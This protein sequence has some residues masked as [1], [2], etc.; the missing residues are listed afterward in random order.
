MFIDDWK[1]L[2]MVEKDFVKSKLIIFKVLWTLVTRLKIYI[3]Q[4]NDVSRLLVDN[5]LVTQNLLY[6]MWLSYFLLVIEFTVVCQE[7]L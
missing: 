4:S 2:M 7:D 6:I 1:G 5:V 3:I